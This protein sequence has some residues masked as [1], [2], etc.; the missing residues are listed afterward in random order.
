VQG[1]SNP[2]ISHDG[3]GL[4]LAITQSLAQMHGGEIDIQSTLGEGT[5]VTIALPFDPIAAQD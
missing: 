1:Q 5:T 4:G 2:Y 3:V